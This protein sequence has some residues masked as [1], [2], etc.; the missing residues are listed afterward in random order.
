[1]NSGNVEN[2]IFPLFIY[3][4]LEKTVLQIHGIHI[5]CRI[6]RIRGIH[7]I[8]GIHRIR[9]ITF[10][11]IGEIG[12]WKWLN[13]GKLEKII[14]QFPWILRIHWIYRIFGIFGIQEFLNSCNSRIFPNFWNLENK[15]LEFGEKISEKSRIS[16]IFQQ[17]KIPSIFPSSKVSRWINIYFIFHKTT[18][19]LIPL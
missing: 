19:P 3:C 14:L 11:K 7:V 10:L 6:H 1:L 17:Q 16:R 8:N 4:K 18:I 2:F 12:E 13:S 15:V 5:I 9:R